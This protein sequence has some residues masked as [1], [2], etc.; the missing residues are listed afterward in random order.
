MVEEVL[1]LDSG[2]NGNQPGRMNFEDRTV[3]CTRDELRRLILFLRRIQA[4]EVRGVDA[5]SLAQINQ[6][7]AKFDCSSEK[8]FQREKSPSSKFMEKTSNFVDRID[9]KMKQ[10]QVDGIKNLDSLKLDNTD[11]EEPIGEEVFLIP[12]PGVEEEFKILTESDVVNQET[13]DID[14]RVSLD[15]DGVS[16]G[17]KS[18]YSEVDENDRASS[19]R[20]VFKFL[21]FLSIS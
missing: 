2:D 20:I 14:D 1:T 10:I 16:R 8:Q 6:I 3:I 13:F 17:S 9:K 7:V 5:M 15:D 21:L 12:L 4:S 19:S 18:N 11:P